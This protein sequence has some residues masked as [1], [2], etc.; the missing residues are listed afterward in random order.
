MELRN[1]TVRISLYKNEHRFQL[2]SASN[3]NPSSVTVPKVKSDNK[4]ES[5]ENNGGRKR[6]LESADDASGCASGDVGTPAKKK[7]ALSINSWLK[8]DEGSTGELVNRF[9]FLD[10]ES[11]YAA[12]VITYDRLLVRYSCF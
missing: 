12:K 11:W 4:G 5:R 7:S 2:K 1:D 6:P 10:A 9:V 8:K 3:S